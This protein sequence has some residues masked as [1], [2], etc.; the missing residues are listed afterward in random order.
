MQEL[1][2]AGRDRMTDRGRK[3]LVR[4]RTEAAMLGQDRIGTEHLLL[5]L[6]ADAGGVASSAVLTLGVG[7]P[8]ARAVVARLMKPAAAATRTDQLQLSE[9][10]RAALE[11]SVAEAHGLRNMYVDTEHLL[12]ALV[13]DPDSGAVRALNDLGLTSE[14]IRSAVLTVLGGPPQG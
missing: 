11:R 13:R 2:A 10:A 7:L 8:G 6:I 1:D 14:A 4:A 9:R 3:V 5:G 12:L